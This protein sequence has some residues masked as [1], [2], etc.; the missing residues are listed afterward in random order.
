MTIAA[1]LVTFFPFLQLVG[2]FYLLYEAVNKKSFL[3]LIYFLITLY[4]IP[5]IIHRIHSLFFPVKYGDSDIF[6]KSYSPWWTS[7]QLQMLYIA[8]PFIETTLRLVPGLYSLWLRCWGSSIGK[9][10]YWTPG[11]SV[12]DRNLLEIGDNCIIGERATFVSHIISPKKGKGVLSIEK[13]IVRKNSFIGAGCVVS[14]GCIIEEETLLKTG[15]ELFPN[16]IYGKEG[17]KQGRIRGQAK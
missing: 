10:V 5:I 12:Y 1:K 13:S 14:S 17:L 3:F 6:N 11:V 7:H 8:Y 2:S 9:N 15:I 16:S 4:L